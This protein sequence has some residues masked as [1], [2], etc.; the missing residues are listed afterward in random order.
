MHPLYDVLQASAN[1]HNVLVIDA[2][3]KLSDDALTRIKQLFWRL[4]PR[5]SRLASCLGVSC[6]S[7]KPMAGG[8]GYK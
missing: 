2:A 8:T 4:V 5:P 3:E 6:S 1:P 7:V